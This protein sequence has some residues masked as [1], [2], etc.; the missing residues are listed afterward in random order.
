MIC[1]INIPGRVGWLINVYEA[2]KSVVISSQVLTLSGKLSSL[3]IFFP[4]YWVC[5]SVLGR[6]NTR[7]NFACLK[8]IAV[9]VKWLKTIFWFLVF[10]IK[11]HSILHT[12]YFQAKMP[13]LIL[14]ILK[15]I[16][17]K[18]NF[19]H[20]NFLWILLKLCRLFLQVKEVKKR[21]ADHIFF[22]SLIVQYMTFRCLFCSH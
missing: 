15:F 10:S 6:F 1:F 7:T 2:A 21:G 14:Q 18:F 4:R 3:Q 19:C 13:L 17:L 11:P 9:V 22:G 20:E 12:M 8:K 16:L 5:G